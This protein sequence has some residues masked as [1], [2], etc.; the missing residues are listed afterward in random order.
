[1]HS[2]RLVT[3]YHGTDR[4]TAERILDG[5]PFHASANEHDW[6]GRG[7]YFWES[8]I[9]RAFRWARDHGAAEPAVVGA[10]V[11]LGNCY[12]LMDTHFTGDLANG[13]VAFH[14]QLKRTR[15]PPPRNRGRGKKARFLDC[16]VVNWWLDRLAEQGEHFHTV[17][18]G[19]DEG[20]PIYPGMAITVESHIQI[21]VRNPA[22]IVGVFRP[23]LF[24]RRARG[25][26]GSA[27]L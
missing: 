21:A 14:E 11:Q 18:R 25:A 20:A 26:F 2:D 19:F 22:C 23:Y 8:G 12:D 10:L 16:A 7:I 27:G 13:A 6:L 3:A 17:R 4:A 24:E 5:A 15:T 9:D 1:M